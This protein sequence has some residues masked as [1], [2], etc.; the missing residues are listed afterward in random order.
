MEI[1]SFLVHFCR[2]PLEIPHV[3]NRGG[4]GVQIKNAMAQCHLESVECHPKNY[5]K[6]FK[7]M[8][9]NLPVTSDKLY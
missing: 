9:N 7:N 5:V 3:L 8:L 4:G 2:G 1:P 6:I